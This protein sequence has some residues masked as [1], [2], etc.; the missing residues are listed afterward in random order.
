VIRLAAHRPAR[1]ET[2][3]EIARLPRWL[4]RPR[5]RLTMLLNPGTPEHIAVPLLGACTRSELREV[6]QSAD[7]PVLLRATAAE[8]L[9]RRPP[10]GVDRADATVH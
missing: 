3:T 7:T 1:V 10:I 6:L 2:L 4:S 9:L 5:V 8:L